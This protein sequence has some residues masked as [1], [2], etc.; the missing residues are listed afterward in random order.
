MSDQ[1]LTKSVTVK[2]IFSYFFSILGPERNYYTLAVVYGVG[3]SVLSLALP[4]SVQAQGPEPVN[5][6][7][8]AWENEA[9]NP[10]ITQRR[11]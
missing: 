11:Q 1:V 3:I 7:G 10:Q 8:I 9:L 6:A 5:P 2:E 4:I